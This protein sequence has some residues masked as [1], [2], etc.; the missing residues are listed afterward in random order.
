MSGSIKPS[1]ATF[2]A[3]MDDIMD[4]V[5]EGKLDDAVKSFKTLGVSEKSD[6]EIK[7]SFKSLITMAKGIKSKPTLN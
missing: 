5:M 7:E 4:K 3:V 6:A 1:Q 2:N